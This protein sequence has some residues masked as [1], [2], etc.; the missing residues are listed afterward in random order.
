MISHNAPALL[1][2]LGFT[3]T[4]AIYSSRILWDAPGF[5]LAVPLQVVSDVGNETNIPTEEDVREMES[6]EFLD[7]IYARITSGQ[8]P[9]AMDAV[10]DHL[11]RQE[12]PT[13]GGHPVEGV[14]S[15]WE[16]HH[17]TKAPRLH[18]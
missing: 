5:A 2:A 16:V 6:D 9:A 3:G 11:D 10:I 13:N 17:G 12:F 4:G 1:T 18:P 14:K 7:G 8:V 15:P